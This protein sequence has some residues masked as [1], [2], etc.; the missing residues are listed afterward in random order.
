VK[1]IFRSTLTW[2]KLLHY[3][4]I[5]LGVILFF[6]QL[7]QGSQAFY[8]Q[9]FHPNQPGYLIAAVGMTFIAYTLQMIAWSQIMAGLGIF[10][11]LLDVLQGYAISFLPRY[12]P[13]TVWGYMSRAEW[14]KSNYHIPYRK[15]TFGSILEIGLILFTTSIVIVVYYLGY[16]WP[17][18]LLFIT[19]LGILGLSWPTWRGSLKLISALFASKQQTQPNDLKPTISP[20]RWFSACLIYLIMWSC[21]GGSLI[22]LLNAFS[23]EH[24]YDIFKPIFIFSLAWL[25]GFVI[26][27]VPSGL[28]I[29]EFALSNLLISQY[30]LPIE[31][32]SAIAVTSRFSIYLAEI[33]WLIIGLYLARI[34]L[35]S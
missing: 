22:L 13:G 17:E 14:F 5:G 24:N 27:I 32:A 28:G 12:I 16:S 33:A 6:Q 8:Q 20:W 1:I 3:L 21:H 25:I 23:I 15:S 2:R 19:I 34:R 18:P 7:M 30:T 9:A 35:R 31:V 10:I 29:R 26:L 11:N 4:G